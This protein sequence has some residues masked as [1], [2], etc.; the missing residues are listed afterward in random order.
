VAPP[1]ILDLLSPNSIFPAQKAGISTAI[2]GPPSQ[3]A[4]AA[5]GFIPDPDQALI[6]DAPEPCVLLCCTRQ[7]GKST[8]T[9]LK[10]VH[11][12]LINP[13]SQIVVAAPSERQSAEFL[14]KAASAFDLLQVPR[15]PA[16]AGL[17]GWVIP[18]GSRLIAL[19]ASARTVRGFSAV[20]LL[21]FEE[22]AFMDD[23]LYHALTP[24]QATVE[25]SALW[26]I[27]TPGAQSGFFHDEWSDSKRTHWRR[28]RI[29]ADQCPRI[30]PQFLEME[31]I[32]KGEAVFRREYMCEFT[33]YGHQVI[34]RE[35]LDA[36]YSDLFEPWNGGRPLWS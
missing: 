12:A 8:L 14:R 35:L 3:W 33:A 4:S 17:L 22:A 23:D 29:P 24:M 19:P 15:R 27:S 2:A 18:N 16:G 7:F 20:G 10:A 6:L 11:H 1:S 25:G 31:R 21:I 13:D 34:S 26:L 28:F 5:L 36:A 30:S 32:R 9:A